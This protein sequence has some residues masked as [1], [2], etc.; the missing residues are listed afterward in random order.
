MK[1]LN[2]AVDLVLFAGLV[3][4][5][6]RL[7]GAQRASAQTE[8][9]GASPSGFTSMIHDNSERMLK[10]G[11]HTF[12][13]DTFGDEG[14]WGDTLQ[15]HQAIEGVSSVESVLE[16]ARRAH[17]HWALRSIWMRCQH[18]WCSNSKWAK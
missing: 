15:L 4:G 12:R 17:C 3:V 2:I 11:Q 16:S 1:N 18:R 5:S 7:V 14:W 6:Y 8:E 13:V 9:T 10:E